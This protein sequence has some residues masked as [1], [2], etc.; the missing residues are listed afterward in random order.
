M[1]RSRR[2][3]ATDLELAGP[4]GVGFRDPLSLFFGGKAHPLP[5]AVLAAAIDTPFFAAIRGLRACL[6]APEVGNGS[7]Y[8]APGI[9][10]TISGDM[11]K[12][13]AL[14]ALADLQGCVVGFA[15]ENLGVPNHTI[16]TQALRRLYAADMEYNRPV[17]T[18]LILR[19]TAL[20]LRDKLRVGFLERC[21][22]R[23]FIVGFLQLFGRYTFG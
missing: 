15:I 17:G 19:Q 7:T 3:Y 5:G 18:S 13:V 1:V 21:N 14:K 22:E 10:F 2:T 6:L 16:G 8:S 9:F 20:C 4:V 12:L 23:L 11:P